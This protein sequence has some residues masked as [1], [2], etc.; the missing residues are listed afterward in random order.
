MASAPALGSL[1]AESIPGIVVKAPSDTGEVS[2]LM[3]EIGQ[4]ESEAIALAVEIRAEVVL[5]DDL[6]ARHVAERMGLH[7]SGVLALLV[8]A[9]REG[10][11][12]QLAPILDVLDS[13]IRFRMSAALRKRTLRDAG[14]AAD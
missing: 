10:H 8:R 1:Y 7:V 5:L 2:R 9:K 3:T 14:E 11:I 6:D 4:G 12:E 13:R